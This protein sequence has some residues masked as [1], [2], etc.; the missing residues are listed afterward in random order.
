MMEHFVLNDSEADDSDYHKQIRHSADMPINTLDNKEFTHQE[1]Q[2][3]RRNGSEDGARRGWYN[4]DSSIQLTS[5]ICVRN[6]QPA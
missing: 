3:S 1:K 5:E 4:T 2:Y 6:L